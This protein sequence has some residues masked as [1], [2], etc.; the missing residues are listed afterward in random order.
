MKVKIRREYL[1]P[2]GYCTGT[3][4]FCLA[5]RYANIE[6]IPLWYVYVSIQKVY[7]FSKK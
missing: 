3:V 6:K 2:L 5:K 4:L 1:S 7:R